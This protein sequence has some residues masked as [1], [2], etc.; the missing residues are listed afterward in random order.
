ME[1]ISYLNGQFLP[2]EKCLV[3][4]EDRGFQFA[5]GIYEVILFYQ[6]KLIDGTWHLERLFRSLNEINL[7][8]SLSKEEINQII[9]DLFAKNNLTAGSVY[10]QI[11]RGTAPRMQGLPA[12]YQPTISMTVSP[13]KNFGEEKLATAITHEDFRWGRCDIKSVGLLASSI[14]RQKAVDSG[15]D[16]AILI[17]D[18]Y[19]T[20]M[21]F[22][23]VFIVNNHNQIVTRKPDNYILNGITR[24]RIIEL[25]KENNIAVI[26]RLILKEELF[27]AKEVFSTS[28]VLTVRPIVKVDDQ[29]IGN[30]KIGEV[31]K[32]LMNS[33]NQ[34]LE[35]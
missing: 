9:L 29:I 30:G 3:H 33:Y 27:F 14:A 28:T 1:R 12:P 31:T 10:L 26:E 5:D 15:F 22:A 32:I 19:V 34:F 2:H 23:N 11:T 13:L 18:D 4:I 25:A 24:R 21:T 8:I 17:R 16:D 20:E 6:K 7:K 35:S